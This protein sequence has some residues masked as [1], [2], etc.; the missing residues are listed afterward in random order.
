MPVNRYFKGKG[1][2]VMESMKERYGE[3]GGKRVFYATSNARGMNPAG[4]NHRK[5]SRRGR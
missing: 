1:R 4:K 2:K 5:R 3:E